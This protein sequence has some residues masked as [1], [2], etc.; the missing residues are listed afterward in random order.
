[1]EKLYGSICLTD[2]PKEMIQTASNGKKYLNIEVFR[3][4]QPSQYGHTHCISVSCKKEDKKEGVNY[5]IG[6]MKESVQTPVQQSS[7]PRNYEKAKS[8]VQEEQTDL[9]F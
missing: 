1:M 7:E 6:K 4:K 9:P 3:M 2:I 5:Y 8:Q